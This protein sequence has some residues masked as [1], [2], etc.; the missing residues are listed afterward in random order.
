MKWVSAAASLLIAFATALPARS[1]DVDL[2]KKLSRDLVEVRDGSLTF[3]EYGVISFPGTSLPS[4][5]M[6]LRAV[7]PADGRISRDVFVS[8]TSGFQATLLAGFRAEAPPPD[9]LP[10]A[11]P[12][13]PTFEYHETDGPS[14]R[15][16]LEVRLRFEDSGIELTMAPREGGDVTRQLL[17]WEQ[18]FE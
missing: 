11:G 12:P 5:R 2:E 9:H 4:R 14:G 8:L 10:I 1:G 6:T 15:A 3:T 18:V 7:A 17:T 13:P 16:D